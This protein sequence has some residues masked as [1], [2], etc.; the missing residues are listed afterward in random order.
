[1][2]SSSSHCAGSHFTYKRVSVE[3]LVCALSLQ[4][5]HQ[6]IRAPFVLNLSVLVLPTR[7]E[8][9]LSSNARAFL[10]STAPVGI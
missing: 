7:P 2:P 6:H 10:L 4:C 5:K 8:R 3:G 9:A 1:M